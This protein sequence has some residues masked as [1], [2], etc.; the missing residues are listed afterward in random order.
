MKTA[1]I[2]FTMVLTV[3]L[4]DGQV[5]LGQWTQSGNIVRL[6]NA[7]NNVIIGANTSVSVGGNK[8]VVR[9]GFA[10]EDPNEPNKTLIMGYNGS[11]GAYLSSWD[12]GTNQ[13]RNLVINAGGGNLGIGVTFP[14]H[15]LEVDGTI[16]ANEIIVDTGGADFVFEDDYALMSLEEVERYIEEHGHLPEIP[17]AAE[18]EAD[19]L[20]LGE[21]QMKLLQKIEELTLYLIEQHQTLA[22]L[23][24]E[25]ALLS[26]R[27]ATLEGADD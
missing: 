5:A 10:M 22:D 4:V 17:S 11:F 25:N 21:M 3:F 8:L 9:G 1:R 15:K 23:Q 7:N 27:L 13:W 2:L 6:T 19:G 20:F 26:E 24:E 16:R 14:T 18:V 12:W